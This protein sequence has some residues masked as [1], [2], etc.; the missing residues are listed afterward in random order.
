M[1]LVRDP[2]CLLILIND[3]REEVIGTLRDEVKTLKYSIS[4]LQQNV[5]ELKASKLLL[6]KKYEE[7]VAKI[8]SLKAQRIDEINVITD[9]EDSEPLEEKMHHRCL[10][11]I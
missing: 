6:E 10:Q 5:K 2:L 8:Q 7:A 3:F 9:S 1:G 4:S 11:L